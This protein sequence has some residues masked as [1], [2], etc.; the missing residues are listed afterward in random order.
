MYYN[1]FICGIS[2]VYFRKIFIQKFGA[3]PRDY[4]IS[5]RLEFAK[6]LLS[7]GEFE[8]SRVAELSGY[9]EPCH[10]SREF[11]KRFGISPKNVTIT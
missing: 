6:Q 4:I 1:G 9:S 5:K 2:E 3:S 7:N 8:V 10:F 11:K